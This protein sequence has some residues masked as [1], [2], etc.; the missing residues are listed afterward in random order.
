MLGQQCRH[1]AYSCVG[2]ISCGAQF[3][4]SGP[5]HLQFPWPAFLLHLQM[6]L[7]ARWPVP[8]RH[9][10][11]PTLVTLEGDLSRGMAG[12]KHGLVKEGTVANGQGFLEARRNF[13]VS[14]V[15]QTTGTKK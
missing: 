11:S 10:F 9:T 13:T 12:A 15:W 3:P 5:L 4:T 7:G 14:L 1:T 8:R 6:G 2:L